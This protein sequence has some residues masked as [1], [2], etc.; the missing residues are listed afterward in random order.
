M[1]LQLKDSKVFVIKWIYLKIFSK[2]RQVYMRI[3]ALFLGENGQ[4]G[5]KYFEY[6]SNKPK[7]KPFEPV[8]MILEQV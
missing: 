2:A 5:S 6:I 1:N 7:I 4:N 3:E 8:F